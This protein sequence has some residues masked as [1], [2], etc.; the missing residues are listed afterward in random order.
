[1]IQNVSGD[2]LLSRAHAIAHGV[3]PNDDFHQG[4][5]LALREHAPSLYKDFRHY[6]HTQ[7]P[8]PGELWAWMGADGQRVVNLF[9][10]E[11]AEGH[12]G[13]KPGKATLSHVRHALKALRKFI[14]DEKLTSIALPKL[15]TGVGGLDWNDVEPLVRE[16]LGDLSIP[17][18]VYTTFHKGEAAAE[19]L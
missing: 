19:K 4:L 11:G 17:V 7:S 16:H 14:E 6:C 3:A 12:H 5:A 13:G 10:Q 8:K 2:I 15:A 1:M 18:I 9:T